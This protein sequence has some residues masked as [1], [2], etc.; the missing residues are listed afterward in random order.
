M[1]LYNNDESKKGDASALPFFY[2]DVGHLF[3][4]YRYIAK[5]LAS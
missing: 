2:V 3:G 4:G 1:Y 5:D